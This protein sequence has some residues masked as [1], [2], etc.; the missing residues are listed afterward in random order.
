MTSV[1]VHNDAATYA[2]TASIVTMGPELILSCLLDLEE[3]SPP[4]SEM[5]SKG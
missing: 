3:A 4:D 1:I 2:E 5:I